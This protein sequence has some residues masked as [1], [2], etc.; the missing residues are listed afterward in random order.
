MVDLEIHDFAASP[1][2][3]HLK[4]TITGSAAT[5]NGTVVPTT[6][7]LARMVSNGEDEVAFFN[8]AEFGQSSK[9]EYALVYEG[10]GKMRAEAEY[11]L[12]GMFAPKEHFLDGWDLVLRPAGYYPVLD[13]NG[14]PVIDQYG[15]P[16]MEWH[17]ANEFSGDF[18][19][20]TA[21]LGSSP[22]ENA[23]CI[24]NEIEDHAGRK[25]TLEYD[26]DR[27]LT[28][29]LYEDG[30]FEAYCYNE[31]QQVTRA[32]DRLGN[33]TRYDYDSQDRVE[34]MYMGL[35]DSNQ[36][37]V[38]P[39]GNTI[40][41]R[42]P[43]NDI[44]SAEYSSVS[45]TYHASGNGIGKLATTTDQRGMV[46][47]YVYDAKHRLEKVIRPAD[48]AG[49]PRPEMVYAYDNAGRI[50][51]I[52]DPEGNVIQHFYN[53][54][55]QLISKLYDDGT[56]EKIVYGTT[57]NT[58][59]LVEKTINRD[60]V[61]N[62]FEYDSADRVT[63]RTT[64]AAKMDGNTEV[65]TPEISTVSS[66][67][68]LDGTE[69][70]RLLTSNGAERQILYDYRGRPKESTVYPSNGEEYTSVQTYVKNQ[71]FSSED[72]FGRKSYHAYDDTD[73][74]LIRS[75][76]GATAEFSLADFDAIFN[77]TRDFTPNANF[78]ISDSVFD[79]DGRL[80]R[81]HDGRNVA[82]KHEYDSLG[83]TVVSIADADYTD[84]STLSNLPAALALRTETDFDD[85][86]NTVEVRS[87]RFFDAN[88]SLGRQNAKENWTY[89]DRGLV[90]THTVGSGS[91]VAATE[92]FVYDLNGRRT[93]RTDFA[94]KVWKMHYED[95]CG[96]VTASENPLG[97]R[98]VG[99]C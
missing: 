44:Q 27:N 90:K 81:S 67:E 6:V 4:A 95:C 94:G 80:I 48:V 75:V 7:G 85:S 20:Y 2:S 89:T 65:P 53:F 5:T 34:A 11:D 66:M 93:E 63:I 83:R 43:A 77:L 86:G 16:V 69:Q 49:G 55:H 62:T 9:S 24:T 54:R 18:E 56:T 78:V 10:G 30:T 61:V 8:L 40:Y 41:D 87:P 59:G 1:G 92:S 50:D 38:D 36:S 13:Q 73:G 96:Q 29:A 23:V 98:H 82:T 14:D 39:Y 33:V 57:G 12:N 91:P 60:G 84:R 52:T 68:Y 31:R 35:T 72:P 97:A 32:R 70:P 46:T 21:R 3:R 15:N 25:Q 19:L 37:T 51:T 22:L 88:D 28:R 26:E 42:C 76:T 71:L 99:L 58:E 47:D 45:Y 64:A 17:D 74:R 79:E